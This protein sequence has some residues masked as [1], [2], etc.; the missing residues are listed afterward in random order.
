MAR[1]PDWARVLSLVTMTSVFLGQRRHLHRQ[2]VHLALDEAHVEE[3][4]FHVAHD[5]RRVAGLAFDF[6]LLVAHPE[7]VEHLREHEV[8]KRCGSPD[9][10]LARQRVAGDERQ[11]VLKLVVQR[12]KP[13][14]QKPPL[15]VEPDAPPDA[16]EEG[17]SEFRL[18]IAQRAG[19][20]SLRDEK[21]GGGV[22]HVGRPRQSQKNFQIPKRHDL[23]LAMIHLGMIRPRRVFRAG[24]RAG[25]RGAVP[26]RAARNGVLPV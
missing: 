21:L 16:V 8:R 22:A 1:G 12:R 4:V 24:R 20:G 19:N 15:V 5:V 23:L 6:H 13:L 18:E 10:H 11:H 14:L 17:D 2:I 25:D 7:I 9:A 26:G 3:A